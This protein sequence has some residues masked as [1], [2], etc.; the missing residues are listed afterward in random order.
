MGSAL[1]GIAWW[2]AATVATHFLIAVALLWWL[3]ESRRQ[4]RSRAELHS[5]LTAFDRLFEVTSDVAADM[6]DHHARMQEFHG[7]INAWKQKKQNSKKA[8]QSLLLAVEQLL[9][10]NLWLM[11]RINSAESQL[12]D[13]R[14]EIQRHASASQRDSLTGLWNRRAFDS[15]LQKQIRAWD[16]QQIPFVLL[17]IDVD[18]FKQINDGFGHPAGDRVLK[19]VVQVLS[20]SV[21]ST[22]AL[23]RYGGDELALILP[24]A[25]VENGRLVAEKI[26]SA[27]AR[28]GNFSDLGVS[29]SVSCGL[30]A[31]QAGDD[32][33][34][35]LRRA[36]DA[37]FVSK[38]HG[39]NRVSLHDGQSCSVI[40]G[41]SVTPQNSTSQGATSQSV[42]AT[43]TLTLQAPP[44]GTMEALEAAC[45]A[46]QEKLDEVTKS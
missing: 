42:A 44:Q 34:S 5:A 37:L 3:L 8:N 25:T 22:D 45:D 21:R 33:A 18:Y 13:Q 20:R 16:E 43:Q 23:Y 4:K 31:A 39:R 19:T 27:V 46:L 17:L 30:A 9:Q 38:E 2:P 15:E 35:I 12:V 14:R 41:E 11:Q 40:S 32:C 29:L 6:E 28:L 1:A 10:S 7:Q 26:R 24:N 36:D